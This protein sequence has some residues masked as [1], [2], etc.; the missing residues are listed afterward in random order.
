MATVSALSVANRR[1]LRTRGFE[2]FVN[3]LQ[4]LDSDSDLVFTVRVDATTGDLTM[5]TIPT[6]TVLLAA[7]ANEGSDDITVSRDVAGVLTAEAAA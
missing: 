4:T 2:D 7:I 3:S 1:K 6:L 5:T